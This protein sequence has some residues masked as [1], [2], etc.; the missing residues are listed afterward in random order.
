LERDIKIILASAS[1]RRAELLSNLHLQFEVVPSSVD[2]WPY[3]GEPI[4]DY[5][6]A[7]ARAKVTSVVT[8][9]SSSFVLGADTVVVTDNE[10]LGKPSGQA[11]ARRMLEMLSGKWHSVITG[12]V[13]RNMDSGIETAGH[14]V[15]R[16]SFTRLTDQDI[17]WYL[18]T[19]E[20]L[21]KAGA[22]AIQG[23]AALFIDQILGSYSN[24]VGLPVQLVYRLLLDAGYPP[25]GE[26]RP[27]R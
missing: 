10:I 14:E 6:I 22:Y 20:P 26:H 25:V 17:G 1:P 24:V 21:D 18:S 4:A 16:V 19:G 7:L 3:Q 8:C 9:F 2:E 12:V 11:D 15:T 23:G 27:G 5:T 13:V